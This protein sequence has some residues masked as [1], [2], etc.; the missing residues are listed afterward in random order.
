MIQPETAEEYPELEEADEEMAPDH[1][2]DKPVSTETADWTVDSLHG[3]Y[4]RG[5]ILLQ[6]D[7]Q[8]EY[9]WKPDLAS[10][11]IESL[12]LDIPI[13]PIYLAKLPSGNHEVIDGQQRLTTIVNFLNGEFAL[14]KLRR[15][16]SAN[17]KKYAAC[18]TR[19]KRKSATPA[20]V[21]SSWTRAPT[22]NCAMRYSSALIAAPSPSL[23]KSYATAF[24]AAISVTC[25]RPSK[26][27]PS[28]VGSKVAPR[29]N[30]VSKSAK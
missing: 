22:R 17:G 30:R 5:K 3:K 4:G 14:Q 20:F 16:A 18:R 11:L 9:V 1:A 25:W 13:P 29:P 19:N 28:G 2:D 12:L 8:R 6:P 23:S 26:K 27:K 24:I 10:R 21:R 7:Y 15:V